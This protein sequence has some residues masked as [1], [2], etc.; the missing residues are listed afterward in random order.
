MHQLYKACRLF[1]PTF[2]ENLTKFLKKKLFVCYFC[3]QDTLSKK[4]LLLSNRFFLFLY[5]TNLKAWWKSATQYREPRT[6]GT[7]EL[8]A[9]LGT[10]RPLGPLVHCSQGNFPKKLANCK[11]LIFVTEIIRPAHR[12]SFLKIHL[13][14]VADHMTLWSGKNFS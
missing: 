6:P 13:G 5:N 4:I 1:S 11:P 3:S 12:Y 8:H 14:H 9:L 10:T 2:V 7:L